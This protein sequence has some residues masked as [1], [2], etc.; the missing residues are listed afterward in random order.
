MDLTKG[1]DRKIG[2]FVR[3]GRKRAQVAAWSG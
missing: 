1:L 3:F 2:A